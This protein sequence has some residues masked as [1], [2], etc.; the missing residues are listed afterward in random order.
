[1]KRLTPLVFFLLIFCGARADDFSDGREAYE[2]EDY[3]TALSLF[4]SAG[5]QGDAA[6]YFWAAGLY[7]QGKG[8]PQDRA[9]GAKWLTLAA[10]QGHLESQVLL[11]NYYLV[12][13]NGTISDENLHLA[14]F[15]FYKAAEQGDPEAQ[16]KL[17]AISQGRDTDEDSISVK[18]YRLAAE[19]GH[20]EAQVKLGMYLFAGIGDQQ[21]LEEA[22]K[23]WRKAAEQG[24]ADGQYWLGIF[25]AM[26][27]RPAFD[28]VKAAKW[29]RKAADQGHVD[30]QYQLAG[31]YIAGRGVAQDYVEAVKWYRMSAEQG[32][33]DAQ[34]SLGHL[35]SSGNNIPKD[36][37][38]AV[39]WLTKAAEQGKAFA[40]H[41]LAI[42]FLQGTGV[43]KDY[44]QG[45]AHLNI[46][47]ALGYE[48]GKTMLTNL[49]PIL[50]KETIS[51]GQSI[52]REIW[53]K[54]KARESD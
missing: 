52:A 36:D 4:Q 21:N 19:Q 22:N 45:Y 31:A 46:A 38:E 30:A 23:W 20:A 42:H 37:S 14:E 32:Q 53:G 54:L 44:A 9:E 40:H 43:P 51:Q 26:S 39:K 2:Q 48:H 16:Y 29:L 34:M 3:K 47:S 18:W 33:A 17:G 11:A 24:N 12:S 28:S 5:D 41:L 7:L 10:E 13:L 50:S 35:Y 15:W 25:F 27:D 8:V 49:E 6:G 1:M